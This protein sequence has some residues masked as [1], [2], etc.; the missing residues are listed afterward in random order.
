MSRYLEHMKLLQPHDTYFGGLVKAAKLYHKYEGLEA[1]QYM[2]MTVC[3]KTSCSMENTNSH[4]RSCGVSERWYI[5]MSID[6]V[7]GVTKVLIGAP[8][9]LYFLLL[10]ERA[11]NGKVMYALQTMTGI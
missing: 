7:F 3:F 1:I 10:P 5:L 9:D 8:K 6:E 11:P 4:T 2:D